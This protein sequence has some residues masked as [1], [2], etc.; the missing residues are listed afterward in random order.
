MTEDVTALID[1]RETSTPHETD[2]LIHNFTNYPQLIVQ[3]NCLALEYA[4]KELK[5]DP[6][7]VLA[8][9]TQSDQ[10]LQYALPGLRNNRDFVLRAVQQNCLALEYASKELKKDPA[11]VLAAVT[12]SDQALQY[13]SPELHNVRDYVLKSVQQSGS[14]FRKVDK[15]EYTIQ[16]LQVTIVSLEGQLKRSRPIDFVDISN[17]ND[18]PQDMTERATKRSRTNP[19]ESKHS[20]LKLLHEQNVQ[21][22]AVKHEK[23]DALAEVQNA[24]DDLEDTQDT[25]TCV[26]MAENN[27][28]TIIDNLKALLRQ[29]GIAETEIIGASTL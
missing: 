16:E 14:A 29:K 25:L 19:K 17:E 7:I 2:I 8:A 24:K 26:T 20:S 11:I 5:K 23:Q 21:L 3:Q 4:S 12:Q 22:V 18:Y 28:M 6:A 13:A 27:K 9:V 15:L 10:A 1:R